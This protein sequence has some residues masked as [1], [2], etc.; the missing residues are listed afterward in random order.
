MKISVCIEAIM[1]QDLLTAIDL[2]TQAGLDAIEFWTWPGKDVDAIDRRARQRG[3]SVAAMCTRNFVL[4]DPAQRDVYLEGLEASIP[5][6]AK[7]GCPTLI[8]QVGQDTGAPREI[9]HQSIVDGLRAAAAILDRAGLTLV[10]EPLNLRVNHPGY[11]LSRS[12][13]A[14]DIVREVAHPRVKVLFDLYHQQITEGDITRRAL[15]ELELIGHF[16]AAGTP[17]RHELTCGELHYPYI[18]ESVERAG[19]QGYVGLEYMPRRRADEGLAE[20]AAMVRA[21]R[22]GV[23]D[24]K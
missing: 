16:H 19:Y 20:V 24:E 6:A 12:Q 23:Y 11:Y 5:V 9:Q 2:T 4:N 7:L 18:L 1:P 14:F 17:G 21:I 22:T 3:L 10:I 8:T 15:A 13:E